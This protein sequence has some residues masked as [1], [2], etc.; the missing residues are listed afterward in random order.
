[1]KFIKK[2]RFENNRSLYVLLHEKTTMTTSPEITKGGRREKWITKKKE[3]WSFIC[4]DFFV[5][6]IVS[7]V[8]DD[9]EY[10]FNGVNR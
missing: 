6:V 7:S 5:L 2:V 3:C 9:N 1:V 10:D 4:R 8:H